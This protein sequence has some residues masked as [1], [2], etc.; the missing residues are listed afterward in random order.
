MK[1]KKLLPLTML[2]A[3]CTYNTYNVDGKGSSES[4]AQSEASCETAIQNQWNCGLYDNEPD[5]KDPGF[6]EGLV[7]ECSKKIKGVD[8]GDTWI[9]CTSNSS[10]KELQDGKCDQYMPQY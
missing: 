10:C 3:A 1:M 9:Y 7:Y 2:V 8:Q 5:A 6:H 4:S